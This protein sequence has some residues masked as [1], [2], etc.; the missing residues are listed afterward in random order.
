M[1]IEP[2]GPFCQSCSMPLTK[3]EDFGTDRTGYRV[4]DYCRHCYAT[5]AFTEPEV[6]LPQMIDR[7]VRIMSAQ[8]IMP[9]TEA[10][11]LLTDVMPRMKRWRVRRTKKIF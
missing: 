11:V 7:C 8:G 9:E 4:N 2:L 1:P 6:T 3:A 5:G 10:R